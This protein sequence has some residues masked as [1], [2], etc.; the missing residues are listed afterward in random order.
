[1]CGINGIIS[2]KQNKQL[3]NDLSK[4]NDLIIHR[5]PDDDGF[6]NYEDR[7][8]M[9]MRRLSIID[10]SSGKQ[11]ISNDEGTIT[12][13][14]NGEIY[15][16]IELRKK[17]ISKGVSF[18]TNSDTEVVLRMYE[19]YGIDFLN[20]L[21]GMFVFSIYDKTVNKVIIARDFF[22]E[23]PLYYTKTDDRFIWA[24]ELKSIVKTLPAKPNI[25]ASSLNLFLQLTY[26]PAPYTIY[27]NIYK[28]EANHY[29][30]FDYMS[31]NAKF[32]KQDLQYFK[33]LSFCFLG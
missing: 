14:F 18:K 1:M 8:L 21:D 16:Y 26:I 24:S 20:E 6:F 31:F 13:V 19:F 2:S 11:P 9:A 32:I 30:E 10:L 17:L 15:N 4:M 22:G 25:N 29:L 7:I 5:G 23:K 28:L 33:I 3:V 27:E 12:I